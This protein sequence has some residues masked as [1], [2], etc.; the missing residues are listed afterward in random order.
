MHCLLHAE[1][2]GAGAARLTLSCHGCHGSFVLYQRAT[3][4]PTCSTA[5]GYESCLAD[6]RTI[7]NN[8]RCIHE[9]QKGVG[10]RDPK[11][12][13]A[14]VCLYEQSIPLLEK[15]VHCSHYGLMELYTG[16][17]VV[18]LAAAEFR[19]AQR[20]QSLALRSC[21]Y[22]YRSTSLQSRGRK[23]IISPQI[24][25]SVAVQYAQSGKLTSY[26]S[27]YTSREG[28][29]QISTAVVMLRTVYGADSAF[30]R[31]VEGYLT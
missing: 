16:Y 19:R 31:E 6:F 13:A 12:D 15:Y 11:I 7:L 27:N 17:V 1:G 5:H 25:P 29:T 18:L 24:H 21:W 20:V 4:H 22:C 9:L 8:Y 30:V 26:L 23:V 2:I 28:F 10:D 3:E 14:L